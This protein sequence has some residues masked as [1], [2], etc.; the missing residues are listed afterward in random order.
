VDEPDDDD[1]GQKRDEIRQAG[2]ATRPQLAIGGFG[3]ESSI[4]VR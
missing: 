3:I 4:G 1:D 2:P